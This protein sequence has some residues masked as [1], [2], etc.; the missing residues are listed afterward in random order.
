MAYIDEIKDRNTGTQLKD[1]LNSFNNYFCS[2]AGSVEETR[3]QVPMYIRK[4]GL[5]ITYVDYEHKV[6]TE[7]YLSNEVDNINWINDNNWAEGNNNLVGDISI[8]STGYWIING[9]VTDI[10]AKGEKGTTPILRSN[11]SKLQVSY[12][13]GNKWEDITDK[14]ISYPD[15]EDITVVEDTSQTQLL[16]FKDRTHNPNLASGKGY[17]IL[18]RHWKEVGG[19][20]KNILT[21]DMI[22]MANTVYEIRYDF[23]L[24]GEEINIPKDCILLFRGGS[25]RNGSII[26]DQTIIDATLYQIFYNVTTKGYSP[27]DCQVEWF[28][29][30]AYNK[31]D[32]EFTYSSDAIQNAL[33]SCFNNIYFNVGVYYIDKTL[34]MSNRKFLNFKGQYENKLYNKPQYEIND[35]NASTLCV[36]TDIDILHINC[37]YVKYSNDIHSSLK[38]LGYG[39]F[40]ASKVENYNSVIIKINIHEVWISGCIIESYLIKRPIDITT[41]EE[42]KKENYGN[43]VGIEINNDSKSGLSI[44]GCTIN[45][46]ITNFRYGIKNNCPKV[47][48]PTSF[49]LK[50][51]IASCITA[52][53]FGESGIEF[54]RLTGSIQAAAFFT[55]ENKN[56]YPLFIGYIKNVYF[57]CLVWDL[58]IK[59]DSGLIFHNSIMNLSDVDTPIIGDLF[60]VYIYNIFGSNI[61]LHNENK[62]LNYISNQVPYNRYSD[63]YIDFLTD[64]YFDHTDY[65]LTTNGFKVIGSPFLFGGYNINGMFIY[66][67]QE[68]NGKSMSLKF[69]T[70]QYP[71]ISKIIVESN[72]SKIG[73]SSYFKEINISYYNSDNLLLLSNDFKKEQETS[74]SYV[75][76]VNSLSGSVKYVIITFKD[77]VFVNDTSFSFIVKAMGF[78]HSYN[79]INTQHNTT[80][81]KGGSFSLHGNR[82]ETVKTDSQI[83]LYNTTNKSYIY[84]TSGMPK[85]TNKDSILT[86]ISNNTTGY[87]NGCRFYMYDNVEPKTFIFD[88]EVNKLFKI[89]MIDSEFKER[90]TFTEKPQNPYIGYQFFC[91]D[92]Q[93]TEGASN[94]IVIYYKGNN[95]WV[96][97][98]GRVVDNNYP[99][100]TSG[101]TAQRPTDIQIG[102]QYYDTT[103]NK[104]IVWN[105]TEWVGNNGYSANYITK[106]MTSERPTLT[107]A[108]DGFEYYDTIL[109]KKILWNR[110]AWVNMD[111]TAL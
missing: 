38:I 28:G 60:K 101:T 2:Y 70:L 37:N 94:G 97:A 41:I 80:I 75:I 56:K 106:G 35:V 13:E 110:I 99:I 30:K 111:G 20:R 59:K 78:R 86:V 42:A 85:Y 49:F 3:K 84:S 9:Q 71:N 58:G 12:D 15:D 33:D 64:D 63:Y 62:Y 72:K 82:Y 4:E 73:I 25:L 74:N 69:N 44:F 52:I 6:H 43:S 109:K 79:H 83:T 47:C 32:I 91:T 34:E 14:F 8:S 66:P 27:S 67:K 57:N 77:F 89:N 108:D 54:A 104:Y 21:Q 102:F 90:G 103:L 65:E 107:N 68:D 5:Y 31:L 87:G 61:S 11:S 92:K 51:N 16:K 93:T 19:V 39:V 40:D 26:L 76:S 17:K 18:R 88:K 1:I 50:C 81:R 23:D 98:L 45:G 95:V 24:S 55:E 29:A 48:Y 53:D 96:D 100:A 10:L 22:D 36:L 46:A 105:G 7:Y